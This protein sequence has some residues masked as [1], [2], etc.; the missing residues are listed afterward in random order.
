[1]EG[2]GLAQEGTPFP[3]RQSD[4]LYEFQVHPAMRKRLGARFCEVFHV[5]KNDELIQFERPSPKLK[6]S[7]C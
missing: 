7:G 1:M 4:A 6:S 2:H 3:V 5:C